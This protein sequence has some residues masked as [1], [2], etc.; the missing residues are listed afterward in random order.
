MDDLFLKPFN[1]LMII[2]MFIFSLPILISGSLHMYVVK[3]DWFVFLKK[4][5]QEQW[6]G[7]NK[8]WRGVVVM[9]LFTIVGVE[10]TKL[11]FTDILLKYK[12]IPFP[13][14]WDTWSKQGELVGTILGLC[15]VLFELPNS[16]IKRRLGI[17]EGQLPTG[18]KEKWRLL[19]LNLDQSDSVL[20]CLFLYS[21]FFGMPGNFFL[22]IFFLG[23]AIHLLMNYTLFLFKLRKNPF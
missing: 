21:I 16:F 2:D 19:F 7:K 1:F 13:F 4:P 12:E 10:I 23:T 9:I 15:Y 14:F 22:G 3:M 6:F 18:E 5:I 11:F 17:L 8:T 20:G